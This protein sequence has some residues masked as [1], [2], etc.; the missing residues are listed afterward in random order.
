M[1]QWEWLPQGGA[2]E[3]LEECLCDEGLDGDGLVGW[4]V[5]L[6]FFGDGAGWDV[7]GGRAMDALLRMR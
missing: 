1:G 2:R 7:G 5:A 4:M 6:V 3:V